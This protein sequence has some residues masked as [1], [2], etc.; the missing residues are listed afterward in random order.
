MASPIAEETAPVASAAVRNSYLGTFQLGNATAHVAPGVEPGQFNLVLALPIKQ[1]ASRSADSVGNSDLRSGSIDPNLPTPNHVQVFYSRDGSD[2]VARIG[3]AFLQLVES[4][5]LRNY[6]DSM[7][8]NGPAEKPVEDSAGRP[9]TAFVAVPPKVRL[10]HFTKGIV[11]PENANRFAEPLDFDVNVL[12]VAGWFLRDTEQREE[13]FVRLA[14]RDEFRSKFGPDGAT[15]WL[16]GIKW[17]LNNLSEVEKSLKPHAMSLS[18]LNEFFRDWNARRDALRDQRN[19]C[20]LD[21]IN[22]GK[23]QELVDASIEMLLR[24]ESDGS[25][26]FTEG[27]AAHPGWTILNL[28]RYWSVVGREHTPELRRVRPVMSPR[29]LEKYIRYH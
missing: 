24:K 23:D 10:E 25:T 8:S 11:G 13:L 2:A 29:V 15:T 28:L 17:S 12:W 26:I 21:E 16:D 18:E 14:T 1:I 27:G 3:D 9:L 7:S 20:L 19:R 4:A 6:L 5:D 22:T